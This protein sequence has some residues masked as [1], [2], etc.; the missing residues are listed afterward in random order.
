MQTIRAVI[1][2]FYPEAIAS[3]RGAKGLGIAAAAV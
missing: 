3:A 1:E 2:R